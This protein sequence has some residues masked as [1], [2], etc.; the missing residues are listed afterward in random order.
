MNKN[1]LFNMKL[2]AL[3]L[4]TV[5]F[6]AI[7]Q[8]KNVISTHRVFPKIDKIVEFEKALAAH[9]QKYHTGD[10]HW[11]VFAIQSGPDI[12]GYHITEGPKT[13]ESEDARGDINPEHQ[14]DWNKN[15]AIYLTDRQSGGYSVYQESLSTI[16]LGEFTDKIQISHIYP[17]PGKNDHVEAMLKKIKK[18]WE[19]SGVT[20]AVYTASGSGP[21]QFT[22]TTRYKQGLKERAVGFRKPF[23]EVYEAANGEGS[24]AQYLKDVAEYVAE[25]WSE[26]LFMR[27]DLSSK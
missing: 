4:L 18:A 17:K 13:W 19:A 1:F 14:A 2:F 26:L 3:V 5:P 15:V 12:G 24:Y 22:L 23:K 27:K 20:V 21:G 25:S 6:A 8:T 10:N 11:R 16:A 9:A 7:S